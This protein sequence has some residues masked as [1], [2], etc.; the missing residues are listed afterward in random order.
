MALA[1]FL[2]R[3]IVQWIA[4]AEVTG[5]ALPVALAGMV[6]TAKAPRAYCCTGMVCRPP[7]EDLD[8]W[9]AALRALPSAHAGLSSPGY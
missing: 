7:A 4:P 1:G 3:R 6:S 2:P 8:A 5:R 9:R